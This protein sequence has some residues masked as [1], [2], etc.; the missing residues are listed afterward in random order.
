MP[1]AIPRLLHVPALL[2]GYTVGHQH[3]LLSNL[4]IATNICESGNHF[5]PSPSRRRSSPFARRSPHA[6]T[7]QPWWH[8]RP[9][10]AEM[11]LACAPRGVAP[12]PLLQAA[13]QPAS[14]PDCPVS[15]AVPAELEGAALS[16]PVAPVAPTAPNVSLYLLVRSDTGQRVPVEEA[17]SLEAAL[18]TEPQPAVVATPAVLQLASLLL[19]AA[20]APQPAHD[21]PPRTTG[22]GTLQAR[23]RPPAVRA[24]R[25]K[26]P[27]IDLASSPARRLTR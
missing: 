12:S 1:V 9:W 13:Q 25:Q 6:R 19:A 4:R 21:S 18:Q 8:P 20:T 23:D 17:A 10:T 22:L 14:L 26:P 27:R 5:S 16:A 24:G 7:P 11:L 15:V 3:P 2:D